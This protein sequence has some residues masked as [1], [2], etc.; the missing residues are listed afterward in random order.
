MGTKE[1][2][3]YSLGDALFSKTQRQIMSLLFGNP[4]KSYY[5][6]EIVRFAGVGIGGVQRELERLS[7]VGLLTIQH[8]GNQKHYQANKKSPIFDELRG[9]VQKTFGVA[10]VLRDVLS[11]YRNI[12]TAAFIYG[13]IAKGTDKSGSDIDVMIISDQVSYPE[14]LNSFSVIENKLG[15]AIN[16]T[17]YKTEEFQKKI[18]TDNS[19]VTRVM[20]QSKIFL[21]GS[22][23]D[24]TTA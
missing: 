16:P 15:R 21:V 4:D 12:V 24:I 5:A 18:T 1:I 19:F 10:D 8:I 2:R 3:T 9:I 22:E 6:N 11:E 7:K 23:D 20:N 14:V 17:I 13:S